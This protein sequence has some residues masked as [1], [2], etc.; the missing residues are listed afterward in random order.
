M[1]KK[2]CGQLDKNKKREINKIIMRNPPT[3]KDINQERL[4]EDIISINQA[5]LT[6]S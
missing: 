5:F 4:F 6:T 3:Q 2:F 1:N